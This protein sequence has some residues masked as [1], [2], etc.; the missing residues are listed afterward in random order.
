[1][2]KVTDEIEKL[3]DTSLPTVILGDYN[4]PRIDWKESRCCS[5]AQKKERALFEFRV[6][7][8]LNQ[9]VKDVTRPGSNNILDLVLC[10]NDC[11]DEEDFLVVPNPVESDHCAIMVSLGSS[12]KEEPRKECRDFD[13]GNYDLIVES[14]L[15]R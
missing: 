10:T 15:V 2:T 9:M 7:N 11:L 5:S 4:C 12:G 14:I 8:W 6:L 1:M 13:R 3:T